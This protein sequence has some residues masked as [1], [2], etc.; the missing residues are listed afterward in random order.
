MMWDCSHCGTRNPGMKGKE[1]ESLKCSTCG[2]E[3]TDEPWVMPDAP[4]TAPHLTG[5]L[6]RKARAGAN[7]ACAFCKG[8]SR[9]GR[10]LCEVCGAPRDGAKVSEP[11]SAPVTPKHTP[12]PMKPKTSPVPVATKPVVGTSPKAPTSPKAT[13][14]YREPLVVEDDVPVPPSWLST[15]DSELVFK[16]ILGVGGAVLLVWLLVWLFTP[17]T[18]VVNV[19]TMTWSREKVLQERHSYAGEGWRSQAPSEVYSWDHCETRQNGTENCHPHDCNCRDVSYE[20]NCT[21]GDSYE[22]NCTTSNNCST[23][24]SSNSN[25]SATC[26]ERCSPTRSCSTCRTPRV[27]QTCSRRECSTCY[28]QCPVYAEWC[29]YH[30]YQWDQISQART[31]GNGHGAVWP[32][33]SARG[34]LQRILSTELYTVRFTDTRSHRAWVRDYSFS[35]YERF[36]MG[37]H[38]NA[39]WT[40]AGG[41]TLKGLA[42]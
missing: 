36:N 31:A 25:G 4:H 21:G 17:N 10:T 3:K 1:R 26:R 14:P 15:I 24:C 23:S 40:R 12:A 2:G 16:V 6:D 19:D 11:A 38:W 42:R 28:D 20:C 9:A 41:F 34:P 37:Q 22:C 13:Y 32:D 7:W 18:T 29:S 5:E 39:E 33:L 27:C 35:A 30:Y 8:E